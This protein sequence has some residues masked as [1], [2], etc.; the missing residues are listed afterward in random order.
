MLI[1]QDVRSAVWKF[2]IDH[3]KELDGGNF[4]FLFATDGP[5]DLFRRIESR[6]NGTY[7]RSNEAAIMR[8]VAMKRA[9]HKSLRH[10]AMVKKSTMDSIDASGS[11]RDRMLLGIYRFASKRLKI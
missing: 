5:D 10:Q 1:P 4:G 7:S 2:L 11:V 8:V 3:S 6:Y 9:E